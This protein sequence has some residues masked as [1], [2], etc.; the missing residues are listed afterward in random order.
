MTFASGP[1]G[2]DFHH[3]ADFDNLFSGN[4]KERTRPLG[5]PAEKDEEPLPPQRHAWLGRRQRIYATQEERRSVKI[6]IQSLCAA[7][8]EQTSNVRR[9]HESVLHHDP[10]DSLG[11]RFD[12]HMMAAG[13]GW[14]AGSHGGQEDQLFVEHF[15]VPY[16]LHERRR[17]E[18]GELGQV[19]GGSRDDR[20]D[21]QGER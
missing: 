18:V 3:D 10:S 21:P 14:D 19:D 9:L 17:R 8:C 1:C 2:L 11:K 7:C 13:D 5:V 16:V 4:M 12:A 6:D 20:A 15:I